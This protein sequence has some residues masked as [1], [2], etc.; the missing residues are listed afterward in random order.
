MALG[1]KEAVLA[2]AETAEGAGALGRAAAGSLP[3]SLFLVGWPR[4][5]STEDLG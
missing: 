5:D 1:Q 2:G 4:R 3:G